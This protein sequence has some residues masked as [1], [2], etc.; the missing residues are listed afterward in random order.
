MFQDRDCK[1]LWRTLKEAYPK[2]PGEVISLSI[3]HEKVTKHCYAFSP[4][5]GWCVGVGDDDD[6]DPAH[7]W[8]WCEDSCK[9]RHQIFNILFVGSDPPAVVLSAHINV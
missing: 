3:P 5:A 9:A 1:Q 7:S 4:G 2:S 6:E 8:G